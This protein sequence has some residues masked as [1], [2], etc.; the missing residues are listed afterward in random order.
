M[1]SVIPQDDSFKQ[2]PSFRLFIHDMKC[3]AA[4]RLKFWT[5]RVAAQLPKSV[6]TSMQV[7]SLACYRCGKLDH[8]TTS[9]ACKQQEGHY[10]VYNASG[11]RRT[12]RDR[13][14][15]RDGTAGPGMSDC[16]TATRPGTANTAYTDASMESAYSRSTL[17]TVTTTLPSIRGDRPTGGSAKRSLSGKGSVLTHDSVSPRK[18][19]S[20]DLSAYPALQAALKTCQSTWFVMRG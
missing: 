9:T 6:T 11:H 1:I 13:D 8:A 18:H 4:L 17:T 2:D 10:D 12:V 19:P 3:Q 16:D 20:T 15:D 7:G 5:H 14:R